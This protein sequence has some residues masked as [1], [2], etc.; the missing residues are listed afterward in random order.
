MQVR[1]VSSSAPTAEF[2]DQGIDNVQATDCKMSA[3]RQRR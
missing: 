3:L 2:A 1:L